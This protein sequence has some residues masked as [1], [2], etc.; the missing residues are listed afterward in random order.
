MLPSS[1]TSF[2][3]INL[4]IPLRTNLEMRKV[5]STIRSTLTR[6]KI[7]TGVPPISNNRPSSSARP[8]VQRS[9]KFMAQPPPTA[10][11]HAF[12]KSRSQR[13]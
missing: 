11:E 9:C 13:V 12:L 4:S 1:S 10:S 6:V 7:V 8:S 5:A 3:R 2:R